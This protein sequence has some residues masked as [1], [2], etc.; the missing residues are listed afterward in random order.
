MKDAQ[1]EDVS[2]IKIKNI[3]KSVVEN[4]DKHKPLTDEQLAKALK[5]QGYPIARRTIAKYREQLGIPV[6]R[7]RKEI[8]YVDF[9]K[10]RKSH[11]FTYLGDFASPFYSFADA[12]VVFSLDTALFPSAKYPVSGDL[13]VDSF[14]VDSFVV[15]SV[16]YYTKA[17]SKPLDSP[18][19]DFF[20]PVLWR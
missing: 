11:R 16:M 20:S 19:S 3:L 4:E 17:F 1:G 9:R 8:W 13:S 14:G 12:V 10:N 15:F 2:T 5:E 6:A 18:T 7:L